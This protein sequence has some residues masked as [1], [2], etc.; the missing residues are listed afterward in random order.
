MRMALVCGGVVVEGVRIAI[1]AEERRGSRGGG[2]GGSGATPINLDGEKEFMAR[3]G[4]F[5][6][7]LINGGLS[8]WEVS[9]GVIIIGGKERRISLFSEPSL[10]LFSVGCL[11]VDIGIW[12]SGGSTI[13]VGGLGKGIR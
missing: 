6:T 5:G 7:D 12:R 1:G 3:I 13:F 2:R 11:T 4:D 9:F 10:H 8:T